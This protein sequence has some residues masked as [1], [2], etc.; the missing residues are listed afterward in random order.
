MYFSR[1]FRANFALLVRR[2]FGFQFAGTGWGKSP[3]E[4]PGFGQARRR[5]EPGFRVLSF[6]FLEENFA[7]LPGR[8]RAPARDR[9]Q[10]G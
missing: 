1:Y 6:E 2:V 4:E 9:G 3:G 7:L 8:I 10:R 5:F